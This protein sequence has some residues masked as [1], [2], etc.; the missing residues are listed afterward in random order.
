MSIP[1]HFK[2]KSVGDELLNKQPVIAIP[3]FFCQQYSISPESSM[4]IHFALFR[5]SMT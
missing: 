5:I 2:A 1:E 3:G 4:L